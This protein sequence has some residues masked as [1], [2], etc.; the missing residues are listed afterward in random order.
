MGV[1]Q[2]LVKLGI[3]AAPVVAKVAKSVAKAVVPVAKKAATKVASIATTTY[4]AI[5]GTS[6]KTQATIATASLIGVGFVSEIKEPADIPKTAAKI[7]TGLVNVGSNIYKFGENPST[8]TLKSIYTENP[9]LATAATALAVSPLIAGAVAVAQKAAPSLLTY[10]GISSVAKAAGQEPVIN[11]QAP[12]A[13]PTGAMPKSAP[14]KAPVAAI[15]ESSGVKEPAA[16]TPVPTEPSPVSIPSTAKG[17]VSA[18]SKKKRRRVPK[19]L[20]RR[21]KVKVRLNIDG[22]EQC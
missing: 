14:E 17:N 18:A 1:I 12:Q 19:C 2:G 6:P 15:P 16:V 9:V 21:S 20:N 10:A 11:I 5:R 22:V 8:T 7:P 4:T 3:K 13:A